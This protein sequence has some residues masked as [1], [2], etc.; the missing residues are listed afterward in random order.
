MSPGPGIQW[1]STLQATESQAGY[2][3]PG[4]AWKSFFILTAHGDRGEEQSV[5]YRARSSVHSTSGPAL[6]GLVH[7]C[8]MGLASSAAQHSS[9]VPVRKQSLEDAQTEETKSAE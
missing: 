9:S 7:F 3:M 8:C 1:R 5:T 2:L 6:M 4:L